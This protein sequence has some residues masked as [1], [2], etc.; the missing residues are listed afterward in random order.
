[1]G[2]FDRAIATADRLITQYGSPF[3][4]LSVS[5]GQYDPELGDLEPTI[6]PVQGRAVRHPDV[7]REIAGAWSDPLI[8][9]KESEIL[10]SSKKVGGGPM[11]EPRI[12]DGFTFDGTEYA[13]LSVSS[14]NLNGEQVIWKVRNVRMSIAYPRAVTIWRLPART[15]VGAQPYAGHIRAQE[16]QQHDQAFPAGIQMRRGGSRPDPDLPDDAAQKTFWRITIPRQFIAQGAIRTRDIVIDDLGERYQ[17]AG[18]AW[19]MLGYELHAERL[20]T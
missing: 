5:D 17:C 15:G 19:S 20:D 13:V 4:L 2:V 11:P 7:A 10:V 3:T 8:P 6:T 18:V 16:I 1:M 9:L 14:L 12:G